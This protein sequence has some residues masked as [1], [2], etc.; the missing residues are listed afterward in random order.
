[1][2]VSGFYTAEIDMLPIDD[3]DELQDQSLLKSVK[4]KASDQPAFGEVSDL[5]DYL[6]K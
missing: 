4:S 6:D 1:M 3:F 2:A 5:I